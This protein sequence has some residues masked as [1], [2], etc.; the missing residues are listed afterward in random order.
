MAR[1]REVGQVAAIAEAVAGTAVPPTNVN[2]MEVFDVGYTP[3]IEVA[4]RSTLEPVFSRRPDGIGN[5][6]STL[7]FKVPL[8]GSGVVDTPPVFGPLLDASGMLET[9]NAA[10]DVTYTPSTPA[11]AGAAAGDTVTIDFYQDGKRYRV[12][13]AMGNPKWV[14]SENEEPYIEFTFVGIY[15]AAVDAPELT[16][17][18]YGSINPP[19]PVNV[20][21]TW[22][23]NELCASTLEIDLGNDVQARR[24]VTAATGIKH[25]HIVDRETQATAD[26]EEEL[27]ATVDWLDEKVQKTLGVL[28]IVIGTVAGNIHTLTFPNCQISDVS[29]AERDGTVI[30]NLTIKAKANTDAGDDEFSYVHS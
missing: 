24:C 17:F 10:V 9:I 4:E 15:N 19:D 1:R 23:G 28:S 26:A 20:T 11:G 3:N 18:A 22:D 2:V 25:A 21:A 29:Y 16:G 8:K 7:T 14:V 5:R 12:H 27:V 30:A 6:M 13:G